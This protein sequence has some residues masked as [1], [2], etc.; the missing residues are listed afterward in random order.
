VAGWGGGGRAGGETR[1]GPRPA[2]AGHLSYG[3]ESTEGGR[4]PA[5]PRRIYVGDADALSRLPLQTTVT[6]PSGGAVECSNEAINATAID[7]DVRVPAG[8][9]CDLSDV[10]VSG[11]L[12]VKPTTGVRV[13]SSSV[14]G[15]LLANGASGASDPQA[16]GTNLLCGTSV[17]GDVQIGGSGSA[18]GWN[19]GGVC[20]GNTVGGDLQFNGNQGSSTITDNT[21]AGD[22]KCAGNAAVA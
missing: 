4:A 15:K 9:W 20:G 8:S 3:K 13:R 19:V 7:G 6:V 12:I 17:G 5:G 14:D 22:L 1:A 10:S 16:S 18:A 11:D 2:R 21:I